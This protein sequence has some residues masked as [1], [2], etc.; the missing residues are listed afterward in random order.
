[1]RRL[2][3]AAVSTL[4]ISICIPGAAHGQDHR[5]GLWGHI[6]GGWGWAGVSCDDCD[7]ERE[8]SGVG[9]LGIG[10]TINDRTLISGELTIWTKAS[11]IVDDLDATVDLYNFAAAVTFYPQATSDFFVKAGIGGAFV[12]MEIDFPGS[13]ITADLG[14]GLGLQA[15]AGYDI[16][17]GRIVSI[18]PGVQ[19]WYGNPGDLKFATETLFSGFSYHVVQVTVGVTIH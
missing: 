3:A 10:W 5:R 6:G 16:R 14:T 11:E 7:E 13:S 19:Y 17:V 9:Q 8:G 2:A 4:V 1:M 12:D 18:T 15:G